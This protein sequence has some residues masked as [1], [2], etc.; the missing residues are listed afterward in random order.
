[1]SC[2]Q[3]CFEKLTSISQNLQDIIH[4][5]TAGSHALVTKWNQKKK[6][7]VKQVLSAKTIPGALFEF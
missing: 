3:L 2:E 6:K 5:I 4:M 1:M 7:V